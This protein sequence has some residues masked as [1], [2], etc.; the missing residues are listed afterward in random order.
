MEKIR[1]EVLSFHIEKALNKKVSSL[2]FMA[3][4]ISNYNYL[5]NDQTVV[6]FKETSLAKFN[7]LILEEQIAT[8]LF[9]LN[10][11]PRHQ[12]YPDLI[13][14]DYL[15]NVTHLTKENYAQ[16]LPQLITAIQTIH[17]LKVETD[18]H[19]DMFARLDYYK[20]TS[21]M[22]TSLSDEK[23]VI[24]TAKAFYESSQKT[25]AHNDLVNGNI[26]IDN[27]QIK[28]IDF[29]YCGLNDPDFDVV[30]F[31]SENAF[32]DD[33]VKTH[34]LREYYQ[35][36]P[37]PEHKLNAYFR[38]ADLLWYYWALFAYKQTKRAIFLEIAHAKKS[39]YCR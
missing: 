15:P 30:S 32:V 37:L 14:V 31:L 38:F 7:S 27:G 12:F 4:G 26:L 1:Q 6:K 5:V 16:Y 35:N 9:S 20:Q 22:T 11:T 21:G 19:F 3:N 17:T 39:S 24:E 10:L 23:N 36:C 34:F 29:E 18:H 25:M 13:A 2:L 33:E 28:L 8:A